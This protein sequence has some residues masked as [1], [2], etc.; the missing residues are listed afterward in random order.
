MRGKTPQAPILQTGT[1]ASSA[2]GS[3]GTNERVRIAA[4]SLAL[5]S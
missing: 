5:R 1:K 4:G 2:G 3:Q